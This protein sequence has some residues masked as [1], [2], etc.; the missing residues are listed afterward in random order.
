MRASDV[1]KTLNDEAMAV[2]N[3][4]PQES[5]EPPVGAYIGQLTARYVAA[6]KPKEQDA[7]DVAPDILAKVRPHLRR[8]ENF[9][10]FVARVGIGTAQI[11][12]FTPEEISTHVRN[13]EEREKDNPP[14]PISYGPRTSSKPQPARKFIALGGLGERE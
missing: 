2:I 11:R 5:P 13:A 14:I 1:T 3:S 10:Q 9:M 7:N 6:G 4:A 8:G 12:Q